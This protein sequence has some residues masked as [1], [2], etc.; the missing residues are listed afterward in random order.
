M[1]NLRDPHLNKV[2]EAHRLVV[3]GMSKR[4]V[5]KQLKVSGHTLNRLLAEYA[6]RR[7]AGT[8]FTD[9]DRVSEADLYTHTF[10]MQILS[11]RRNK[12][13]VK[14]WPSSKDSPDG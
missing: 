13:G 5:S 14:I 6:E 12:E 4:K 11:D 1:P 9:L 3:I 10:Q 8:L 2:R 7:K